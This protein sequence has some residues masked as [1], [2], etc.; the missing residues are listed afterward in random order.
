VP[1]QGVW[2]A[3]FVRLLSAHP[4][5]RC[6]AQSVPVR[7]SDGRRLDGFVEQFQSP[8]MTLWAFETACVCN[9]CRCADLT[10]SSPVE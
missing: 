9:R 7:A 4:D 2:P 5:L 10:L 6:R 8:T 3:E 1:R